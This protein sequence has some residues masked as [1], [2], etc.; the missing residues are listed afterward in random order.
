MKNKQQAPMIVYAP[1]PAPPTGGGGSFA[2]GFSDELGRSAARAAPTLIVVGIVLYVAVRIRGWITSKLRNV[3]VETQQH[4]QHAQMGVKIV[5]AT[6]QDE[7][8]P[9]TSNKIEYIQIARGRS[10]R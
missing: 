2:S 10:R 6:M 1:P 5:D 7:P 3:Q 4:H 9:K 8:I